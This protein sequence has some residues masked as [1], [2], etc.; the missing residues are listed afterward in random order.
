MT[1]IEIQKEIEALNKEINKKITDGVFILMPSI[2]EN[3]L[4]IEELRKKCM[5]VYTDN[6]CIYCGVEREDGKDF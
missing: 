4:K 3:L 2:S 5:H 6:K 1:N